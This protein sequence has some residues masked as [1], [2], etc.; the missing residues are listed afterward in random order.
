[1]LRAQT[2][3]ESCKCMS[4]LIN[5]LITI[6]LSRVHIITTH[7]ATALINAILSNLCVITSRPYGC[8]SINL[9]NSP[10]ANVAR[11]RGARR[12]SIELSRKF[13]RCRKI[14]H[15]SCYLIYFNLDLI[16]LI[17]VCA[18]VFWKTKLP[19]KQKNAL[20]NSS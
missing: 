8:G 2:Y 13:S 1:M 7:H 6:I 15:S 3:N 14:C 11:A 9:K 5:K 20:N 17:I 12:L 10:S 4:R 18:P 16:V 19:Q